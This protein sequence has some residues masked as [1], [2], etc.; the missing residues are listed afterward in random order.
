MLTISCGLAFVLF[1]YD[2]GVMS[3]LLTGAAFTT[4]FPEIGRIF[5]GVAADRRHY[6]HRHWFRIFAR[7]R[8]GYLRDWVSFRI[9][10]HFLLR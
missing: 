8:G 1:G 4:Q 6:I 10:I 2:Q 9:H 3:G 5:R 7:D